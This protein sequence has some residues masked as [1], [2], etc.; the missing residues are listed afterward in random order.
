MKVDLR[1]DLMFNIYINIRMSIVWL[2]LELLR[3]TRNSVA[4]IVIGSH[5]QRVRIPSPIRYLRRVAAEVLH[6]G[7]S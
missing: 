7:V 4:L 1:T 5:C 2:F 3:L 6:V